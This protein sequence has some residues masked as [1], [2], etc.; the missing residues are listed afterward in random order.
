MNLNAKQRKQINQ[1]R[2]LKGFT[3]EDICAELGVSR[4]TYYK[5]LRT[6]DHRAIW[7]GARGSCQ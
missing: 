4:S 1:F 6:G 5:R 2:R 7:R 3:V